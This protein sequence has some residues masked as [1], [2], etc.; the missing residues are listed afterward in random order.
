MNQA[1]GIAP[2][3]GTPDVLDVLGIE[4]SVRPAVRVRGHGY[5]R[6]IALYLSLY[7]DELDERAEAFWSH[8]PREGAE[9][10]WSELELTDALLHVAANGLVTVARGAAC[11]FP[12]YYT[13]ERGRLR[14]A[15]SLRI[16]EGA[17]LSRAGLLTA[18]AGACLHSSYEVNAVADTPLAGWRRLRRGAVTRFDGSAL[19]SEEYMRP[20][21]AATASTRDEVC[22]EVRAAFDAYGRSQRRVRSSVVEASGGFDSTLAAAVPCRHAMRGVSVMFPYYE[23]RFERSVQQ[24]TAEHLGIPRDE[25]DGSALFPYAPAT[26]PVRFDEPSV[27]VTG[28]RHAEEV[29][30]FAARHGAERIYTGHG[31]DQ[32]FAT[33]LLDREPL[34]SNNLESGPFSREAWQVVQRAMDTT[35]GSD[36]LDRSLGTLVYDARP[37]VWIR[38]TL[39]PIHRTPF[40]DLRVFRSALAWSGWCRQHRVLPDKSILAEAAGDLLPPAV[41]ARKGKVAYDGVWMRAYQ[42]HADH[43]ASLFEQVGAVL[44]HLGVSPRWLQRRARALGEWRDR[45][46]REVLALY[47]IAVWLSAWGITRIDDAAWAD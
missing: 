21:R 38:E 42:R 32:C 45:S 40:S 14:F 7:D 19:A 11:T 24:A 9:P 18:V 4:V 36:S 39:G 33:D 10:Q 31:G 25:L 5:G 30:R 3:R 8:L 1:V 13:A 26:V 41:I 12:L 29:A 6:G 46:D 17:P 2:S 16:L 47:A 23:F 34:V 22:R 44:A 20:R 15:T 43:I 37:D 27:F 35:R 28:I